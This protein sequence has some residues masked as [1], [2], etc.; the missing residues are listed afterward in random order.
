MDSTLDSIPTRPNYTSIDVAHKCI[1]EAFAGLEALVQLNIQ[2][3]KTTLSEQQALVHAALSAQTL[4][5]VID[6]QTRQLP[7]ATTK[8][9]AYWRHVEDIAA[10]T[11]SN[12][13]SVMHEQAGSPLHSAPT[14]LHV[15]NGRLD[16]W[17]RSSSSQPSGS[18]AAAGNATAP[19]IVDSAGNPVAS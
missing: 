19:A 1:S 10:Q 13:F 15:A 6:L 12:T 14:S 8:T 7:A 18:Q 16:A 2:T 17:D 4:S 3:V 5:E 11:G 9:F